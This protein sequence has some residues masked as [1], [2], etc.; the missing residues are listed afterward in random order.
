MNP[1]LKTTAEITTAAIKLLCHEIGPAN[2]AR[3]ISQFTAG[4]GDYTRDRDAI[5]A[6]RSVSD[7]VAEIKDR[8]PKL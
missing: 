8:R 7:L 2:T 4:S 3:F 6:D 5:L 1:E